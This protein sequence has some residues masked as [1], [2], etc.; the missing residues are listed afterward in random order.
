MKVTGST[1]KSI[2]L[3]PCGMG[4][5]MDNNALSRISQDV[6]GYY[7]TS[8]A[9]SDDY[10]KFGYAFYFN[11]ESYYYNGG[12]NVSISGAAIRPVK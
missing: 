8:E 3:P 2:F 12:L 6:T 1:G 11:S 4:V 7:W 10:G 5:G 9:Y